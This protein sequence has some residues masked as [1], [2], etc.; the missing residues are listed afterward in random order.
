[1]HFHSYK[2]I[3][4]FCYFFL[5]WWVGSALAVLEGHTGAVYCLAECRK[6][7]GRLVLISGSVDK[8]ILLWTESDP[9]GEWR[10]QISYISS[11]TSLWSRA[12]NQL[13]FTAGDALPFT[14]TGQLLGHGGAVWSLAVLRDY[15]LCSGSQDSTIRIW[16]L[17]FLCCLRTLSG[18]SAAIYC[19]IEWT[20]GLILSGYCNRQIYDRAILT[21]KSMIA[22]NLL[23][24][25]YNSK[26]IVYWYFILTKSYLIGISHRN[27]I[28]LDR[29]IK[30][31]VVGMWIALPPC[32]PI[33]L[34]IVGLRV[35]IK[36]QMAE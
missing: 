20:D 34:I 2:V 13:L 18:H 10:D 6:G 3:T 36:W 16:D 31:C 28:L 22:N 11:A 25:N 35:S 26:K 1:M 21:N 23:I 27:A 12:L 9:G 5:L 15:R 19:M 29:M 7:D 30:P 4:V 8:G 32:G 33:Q 14:R 24:C 17:T